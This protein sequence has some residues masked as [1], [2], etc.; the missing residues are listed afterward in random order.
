[1]MTLDARHEEA[2]L[3]D[4]LNDRAPA[5]P[6]HLDPLQPTPRCHRLGRYATLTFRGSPFNCEIPWSA[7][8]IMVSH[9]TREPFLFPDDIPVEVVAETIR[10]EREEEEQI[11]AQRSQDRGQ[12]A[13]SAA[14]HF[15]SS[16]PTGPHQ[17]RTRTMSPTP[18]RPH[19]MQPG[20]T[21]NA[22]PRGE[23]SPTYTI[24]TL[25]PGQVGGEDQR[26]TEW[27]ELWLAACQRPSPTMSLPHLMYADAWGVRDPCSPTLD[28]R[29]FYRASRMNRHERFS[30]E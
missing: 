24:M 21:P 17:L 27:N 16:K 1:M 10:R 2:S 29:T 9:E 15:A 26:Q 7:I 28:P 6:Q 19:P 22:P 5:G 25:N 11:A 18:C 12:R 20:K 30:P 13:S 4:Y 3:P 14:R 23:I 8:Y